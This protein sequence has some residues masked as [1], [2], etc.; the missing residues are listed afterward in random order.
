VGTNWSIPTAD[1]RQSRFRTVLLAALNTR[2]YGPLLESAA[3]GTPEEIA[4]L[5]SIEDA[6][7]RLP[8]VDP[9]ASQVHSSAFLNR[10]EVENR[11]SDLFWPLPP[12]AR[13][14]VLM[15][16]FWRRGG[17]Q[18]F[19]QEQRSEIASYAPEALAGSVTELR[20]LADAVEDRGVRFPRLT[21]SVIAFAT[22]RQGFLSDEVRELFWRVFKVPVFGQILSPGGAILAWECEAHEGFHFDRDCAVFQT[23]SGG[24]EPELLVTSLVDLRRPVI[25]LA[26]ALTGTVEYST[27]GCGQSGPRLMGLRRRPFPKAKPAA[28]FTACAAE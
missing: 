13:T 4:E 9:S 23:Q 19:R 5:D 25:R 6:L 24:G 2:F 3:L 26:T 16:G 20:A 27:C 14:A 17:I 21:H 18:A 22:L 12:A 1:I 15:D 8:S 11:R 10:N 28:A 7:A